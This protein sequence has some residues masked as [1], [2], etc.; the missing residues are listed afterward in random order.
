MLL[1]LECGSRLT[2]LAR[3]ALLALT[4]LLTCRRLWI[5]PLAQA[6]QSR[7]L[8]V[9]SRSL[10]FNWLLTSSTPL[11]MASVLFHLSLYQTFLV[12]TASPISALLIK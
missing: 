2:F 10:S 4:I 5:S 3:S 12:S 8:A 11:W 6:L 7:F 9:W 1:T